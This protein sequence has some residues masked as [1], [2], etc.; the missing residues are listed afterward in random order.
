MHYTMTMTFI[1]NLA[2]GSNETAFPVLARAPVGCKK[3]FKERI[4][5]TITLRL[6]IKEY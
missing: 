6:M 2:N 1:Q 3:M 4:L 5:L